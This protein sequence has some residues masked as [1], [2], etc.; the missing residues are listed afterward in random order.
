MGDLTPLRGDTSLS[1]AAAP[2]ARRRSARSRCPLHAQASSATNATRFS[3][4]SASSSAWRSLR[5][6]STQTER[7]EEPAAGSLVADEAK[8]GVLQHEHGCR[9]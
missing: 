6:P 9:G 3:V 5:A 1:A 7:K 8:G 4:R 2:T